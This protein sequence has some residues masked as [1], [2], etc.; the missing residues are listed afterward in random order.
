MD[1]GS[2]HTQG[3]NSTPGRSQT[4]RCL[5]E[6]FA[7]GRSGNGLREVVNRAK[8]SGAS[9]PRRIHRSSVLTQTCDYV[10]VGNDRWGVGPR[11]DVLLLK[12]AQYHDRNRLSNSRF[13]HF[14]RAGM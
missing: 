11:S 5:L 2:E 3:I 1:S 4:R 9:G 7:R 14:Q 6:D 8:P 10:G 13:A 12:V